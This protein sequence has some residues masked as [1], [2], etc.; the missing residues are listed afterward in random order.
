MLPLM[1]VLCAQA[2]DLTLA[3]GQSHTVAGT[4]TYDRV[5]VNG[6]LTVGAGATLKVGSICVATNISGTANLVLEENAKLIVLNTGTYD[7]V[8]GA[9]GGTANVEMK[10]G[11]TNPSFAS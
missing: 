7:C 10:S 5:V 6:D 2:D 11:S 9:A 1:C 4:E 8:L 3:P